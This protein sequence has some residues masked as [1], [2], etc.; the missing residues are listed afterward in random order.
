MTGWL[1]FGIAGVVISAWWAIQ[2]ERNHWRW[3]R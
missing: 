3:R 1:I 2:H